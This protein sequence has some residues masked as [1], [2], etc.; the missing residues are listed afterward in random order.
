[1]KSRFRFHLCCVC[2]LALAIVGC[3]V[4]RP[5]DVISESKME[6]LLYDYHLAKSMGDNLPYSENYKKAL[7]LD[8]VFKKYGTTEA[9]FDSSL[10]WYTRNTE[11]LSK[12][13][14]KVSKR[15]KA[16]QNEINHLIALRDN[17]PKMSEPGDS[18][19]VW[20]WKRLI[21]LTGE[22]MNDQYAFVLPADTNYK[23]RDTLVWEVRYRFLEPM[24]ADSLR[25]VTMA[26][27]V[28][29]EKDTLN[30]LETITDPGVYQLRLSADTLGVMKEIKGFIYYPGV[31]GE[32]AGAL[33]ADRFSLTR[34]HCSD[35]LSVAER[36]SI[37]QLE[38]LKTDSLK[39]VSDQKDTK[40]SKDSLRKVDDLKDNQRI[41]PEEMNRRRTVTPEKKPEQIEVEQ[42]IQQEKIEQRRERQLNQR[43]NQQRR[44]SPS[45]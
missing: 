6:N 10:V 42:H 45:R 29:Y 26:M 41:S 5:D 14:E 27:Q 9:T 19:D 30:R 12:I 8:A 2:M 17:K 21:R 15:L 37:N 25:A 28:I 38:A 20:P 11:V 4:K 13:Y 24:L 1:M 16:Q 34:Y 32:K 33:L 39:K 31:R 35:S 44:Q 22:M 7:Y 3:K 43:R 23:D 36:D 40:I 18:I